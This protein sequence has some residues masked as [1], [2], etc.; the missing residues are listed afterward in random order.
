M[1]WL[2]PTTLSV[3]VETQSREENTKPDAVRAQ[4]LDVA[5]VVCVAMARQQV[6]SG[7]L[8]FLPDTQKSFDKPKPST[9]KYFVQQPTN[10]GRFNH[11]LHFAIVIKNV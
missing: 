3:Q 10:N 9:K 4:K 11:S 2:S 8:V 5:P 6:W 1:L 7:G